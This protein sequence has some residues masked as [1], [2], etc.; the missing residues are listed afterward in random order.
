MPTE[1]FE[2]YDLTRDLTKQA[3]KSICYAPFVSMLLDP[4]G[5]VRACCQDWTHSLGR[6]TDRSL[7]E[8]WSGDE[9]RAMRARMQAYDLPSGCAT[10]KWEIEHNNPQGAFSKIFDTISV[11]EEQPQWPK[12]IW[13]ALSNTCNLEC[14]QC[15]G[16]FSS[17]IRKNR[18]GLA[19]LPRVY[20]DDFFAEIRGF[21]PHLEQAVFLGG[22]S[23]LCPENF[24]IW[25]MMIEDGLRTPFFVTTNGTV[26]DRRVE[27]VLEHL[28]CTVSVSLD[29]AT[30]QTVESIRRNAKFDVVMKNIRK[31]IEARGRANFGLSYCLMPQNQHEFAD[32]LLL[33]DE[34]GCNASV[35]KIYWPPRFSMNTLSTKE[36]ETI[37]QQWERRDAE[38]RVQLSPHNL[39]AWSQQLVELKRLAGASLTLPS[40]FLGGVSSRLEH[41]SAEPSAPAAE[42]LI[43]RYRHELSEWCNGGNVSQICVDSNDRV[44]VNSAGFAGLNPTRV[45]G[46]ELTDVFVELRD[47]YGTEVMIEK[48]QLTGR[49][50]DRTLLFS[51]TSRT[52]TRIRWI[53]VAN[54]VS[55]GQGATI[56]AATRS[57]E[58]LLPIIQP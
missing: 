34:L 31:F 12:T 26:F 18:E 25:D 43:D 40:I 28:P 9:M 16:E 35:N 3:V 15:V 49:I 46:R 7:T 41:G 54:D 36:L 32:F 53:A 19:P 56:L 44:D 4:R 22:E 50:L 39:D 13:F 2:Q 27:R 29:G 52:P 48:D 30:R 42:T 6:I 24:R 55:S 14:V 47:Y 57:A 8:I 38:L 20:Q 17:S 1:A 45:A 10:C 5:H 51:Q 11:R 21:L 33:A 23:F 37:V 58:G